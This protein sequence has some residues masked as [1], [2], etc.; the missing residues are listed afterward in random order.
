MNYDYEAT[1]GFYIPWEGQAYQTVLDKLYR[2]HINNLIK[3]YITIKSHILWKIIN[4][5]VSF[6]EGKKTVGIHIRGTDKH[7]EAPPIDI[8]KFIE[9]ANK[10]SDHQFLVASDEYAIID[11]LKKELK[12]NVIYYDAF[13]SN[14]TGAIHKINPCEQIGQ[15][16]LIEVLL[17]SYCDIF[18]HSISN[19]S[20]AVLFFNPELHNIYLDPY[21][22]LEL[23][24]Y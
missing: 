17:L 11:K 16:V 9:I 24:P 10:Y 8:S 12:G 18:I 14:Q 4:F 20:T 23:E 6:M 5:Y 22:N 3:K 2:K 19:V 21:N 13:R 15:E 7:S 1:N